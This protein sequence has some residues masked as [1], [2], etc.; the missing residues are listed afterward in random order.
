MEKNLYMKKI[1]NIIRK[2]IEWFDPYRQ[3]FLFLP[4]SFVRIL[5]VVFLCVWL[6]KHVDYSV[7]YTPAWVIVLR[8]PLVYLPNFLVHEMLGHNLVGYIL[9][10]LLYPISSSL[11]SWLLIFAGNGVETLLPLCLY[12]GALRLQ[13]GRWLAPGLLYWL[14]TTL[15]DAG[16]YASDAT[17]CSFPLASADM[18][19]SFR[20]GSGVCGDWHNLLSPLGLLSYDQLIAG[21]LVSLGIFCFIMAVWSVW[22]Y[23]FHAEED[24]KNTRKTEF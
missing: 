9:F 2:V 17:A 12:L 23:I 5:V 11:G 1:K 22:H 6:T 21:I 19:R 24:Y 8:N 18:I 15:V 16:I 3:S 10:Y 4:W 7:S 14:S 13:G 20:A